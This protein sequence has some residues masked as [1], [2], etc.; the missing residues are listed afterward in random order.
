[1]KV[2]FY[3]TLRQIAGGKDVMLD[4]GDGATVAVLL[5]EVVERFPDMQRE[6]FDENGQLFRH[7]NVFVNGQ[8]T[9]NLDTGLDTAITSADKIDVFPAVAGG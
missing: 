3:A 7:V 4:V 9:H 2:S 1:V 8:S 5:G 6:L